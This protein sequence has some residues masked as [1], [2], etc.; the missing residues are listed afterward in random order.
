MSRQD[1]YSTT[2]SNLYALYEYIKS[3]EDSLLNHVRKVVNDPITQ[4]SKPYREQSISRRPDAKSIRWQAKK[5]FIQNANPYAPEVVFENHAE[6]DLD[7]LEN[8]WVKKI[9]QVTVNTLSYL[10]E[11]YLAIL[12]RLQAEYEE[13]ERQI[14]QKQ[15]EYSRVRMNP[16]VDADYKRKLTDRIS[17]LMRE[18]NE[19]SERMGFIQSIVQDVK[20]MKGTLVHFEHDTWLSELKGAERV[21]KPTRRL[22]QGHRTS[23]IYRFYK[24]LVVRQKGR[25]SEYISF[26]HKKTSKLFEYYTVIMIAHILQSI[27]L[28]W[29]HGWIADSDNP[30]AFNGELPPESHLI[31][32]NNNYRVTLDYD[33]EYFD[34][35]DDPHTPQFVS[36]YAKHRRPDILV[37]AFDRKTGALCRAMIVEVKCCKTRNIQIDGGAD[38]EA[39]SQIKQYAGYGYSD[40]QHI[41]RGIIDRVVLVYPKQD[42]LIRNYYF[43]YKFSFIPIQPNEVLEETEG[44]QELKQ[45]LLE[46]LPEDIQTEEETA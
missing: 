19:L 20:R 27:G 36:N 25:E 16:K 29:T 41:H 37:A 5:G 15:R 6:P 45:E 8:L 18:M 23:Y 42:H 40:T 2:Q 13:K 28:E 21:R 14:Q 24:D 38:T 9:I 12:N 11:N 10:E 35:P 17:G 4:L 39:I 32:E 33:K 3:E 44:Y 30:T 46:I 26:P 1:R 22:F 31:F 43:L 7:T 34:E